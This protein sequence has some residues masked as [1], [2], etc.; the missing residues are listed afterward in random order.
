[1]RKMLSIMLTQRGHEV[2][3]AGNGA[4]G[5]ALQRE[6]PAD[7]VLT[8]IIMPERDGIEALMELRR[9]QPA[10]PVIAMSGGG[11]VSATDYL[12]MAQKLGASATLAKPFSQDELFAAITRSLLQAKLW[13]AKS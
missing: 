3:E 9:R 8:D 12:V 1:M 4:E 11:R 5:L 2:V 13:R 6:Q 10:V 7:L